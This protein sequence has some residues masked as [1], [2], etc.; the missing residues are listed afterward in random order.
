MA[1][2]YH[3]PLFVLLLLFSFYSCK[4]EDELSIKSLKGDY[5][6]VSSE[7]PQHNGSS[8]HPLYTYSPAQLGK[9]YGLRITKKGVCELYENGK[10]I[11]SGTVTKT[12]PDPSNQLYSGYL[13][14][15]LFDWTNRED[16]ILCIRD[17]NR[18]VHLNWPIEGYKNVFQ[19]MN[20]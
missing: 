17:K 4:K 15:L 18:F 12:S 11:D 20:N 9:N 10:R 7:S 16:M 19:R 8:S 1:S 6:W 13:G 14:Y 5:D 3:S 2:K